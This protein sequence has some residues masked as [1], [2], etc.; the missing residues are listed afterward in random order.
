[1]STKKCPCLM[2][3]NAIARCDAVSRLS[4]GEGIYYCPKSRSQYKVTA[5]CWKIPFDYKN[6]K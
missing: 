5:T 2:E 1:M 3:E 4:R 6:M